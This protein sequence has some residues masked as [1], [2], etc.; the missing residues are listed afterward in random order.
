MTVKSV[1]KIT[2]HL[3]RAR[4]RLPQ[5]YKDATGKFAVSWDS[6][7][8]SGWYG[9]LDSFS[10]RAQ[11][12]EDV[13]YEMLT[14]RGINT[15][16]GIN[17]DRIGEILGVSREGLTDALYLDA[18]FAQIIANNSDATARD[19]LSVVQL[20]VG[21]DLRLLNLIED[22]PAKVTLNYLAEN[23][24]VIDSSNQNISVRESS[25]AIAVTDYPTYVF[26]ADG[27]ITVSNRV[28]VTMPPLSDVVFRS[29]N[30]GSN[31]YQFNNPNHYII[32]TFIPLVSGNVDEM[33]WMCRTFGSPDAD[34]FLE[35]R[36]FDGIGDPGD[37]TQVLIATSNVVNTASMPTSQAF[38]PFTFGAPFALDDAKTYTVAMK[39]QNVILL[40]TNNRIIGGGSTF[41]DYANG[42]AFAFNGFTTSPVLTDTDFGVTF[43][44]EF[45]SPIISLDIYMF[46]DT[47]AVDFD[48]ALSNNWKNG[49]YIEFEDA[50]SVVWRLTNNLT[51]TTHTA[52]SSGN[53]R[54]FK[55]Q[56]RNSSGVDYPIDILEG[57]LPS[58]P[59]DF[60]A[61]FVPYNNTQEA[62]WDTNNPIGFES[63]FGI[64][65]L[66]DIALP[67]GNY[68]A[69]Q[70]ADLLAGEIEA[71]WGSPIS[72]DFNAATR[73]YTLDV[74]G[75]FT[76]GEV[77]VKD[78]GPTIGFEINEI[79]T[80]VA[81]GDPVTGPTFIASTLLDALEAA[82][83]AGV[84]VNTTQSSVGD[85]FGFTGS[86]PI[87]GIV[88]LGYG[89]LLGGTSLTTFNSYMY[90]SG[91][92]AGADAI[93]MAT[94]DRFSFLLE[95]SLV[96]NFIAD[97]Q[98]TNQGFQYIDPSG[99]A[100]R[101]EGPYVLI[102][103]SSSTLNHTFVNVYIAD[104]PSTSPQSPAGIVYI[105]GVATPYAT[106]QGAIQPWNVDDTN[107]YIVNPDSLQ[108]LTITPTS[109][110][111]G[112]NYATIL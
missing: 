59:D 83:A 107:F 82:K 40:D 96:A 3:L 27:A 7:Q 97:L 70:I 18:I 36:E 67:S 80:G 23:Y 73:V 41:S 109:V 47:N 101:Y 98:A 48:N 25:V 61:N 87:P 56:V 65:D 54:T 33:E 91:G 68:F 21:D 89:S 13:M 16:E 32:Q 17:L 5:Q 20:I 45:Q 11:E 30:N 37:N 34:A 72:V 112:G 4:K 60:L 6:E 106:A 88:T 57:G 10:R 38:Q 77:H 12:M 19:L 99:Q 95:D 79:L 93:E 31:I 85:Q 78:F 15:A 102:D 84:D 92:K 24:F 64:P 103:T 26:P 42:Q 51:F 63:G 52:S 58:N 55:L 35:V 108:Y 66:I 2:D 53:Y 100:I 9:I 50:S 8:V 14:E 49:N 81:V 69:F 105:N 94:V 28:E 76:N 62:L 86:E 22:F 43:E 104:P 90:P 29:T 110:V 39:V 1:E 74:A 71:A 44:T 46:N 75:S 111:G